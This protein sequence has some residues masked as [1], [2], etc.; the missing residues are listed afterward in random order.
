MFTFRL[1]FIELKRIGYSLPKIFIGLAVSVIFVSI[2][3][4]CAVFFV[5]AH[6]NS[7]S[8]ITVYVPEN[9][10]FF[11]M[12]VDIFSKTDGIKDLYEVNKVSDRD[13]VRKSVENGEALTGI[14]LDDNFIDSIMN[15]KENI[16]I[17]VFL[18][19]K[20]KTLNTV[21][22]N[23]ADCAKNILEY[24]QSAIYSSEMIYSEKMGM[25]MPGELNKKIN[26]KYINI[27]ASRN[28]YF[29]LRNGE[30][31][32]NLTEY[33]ISMLFP[34]FLILF[35]I[36]LGSLLYSFNKCFYKCADCGFLSVV[37][38]HNI[39]IF[40]MLFF[41]C[42]IVVAFLSAFGV[43]V[44]I[45]FFPLSFAVFSVSVIINTVYFIAD[46][47]IG[48]G[49][50]LF[51]IMLIFSFFGGA[52]VPSAFLPDWIKD[53]QIYSPVY[54]IGSQFFSLFA[55]NYNIQ[56]LF[57]NICICFF[58]YVVAFAWGCKK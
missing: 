53:I 3:A 58:C 26:I 24:V 56:N 27:F 9:N 49:V 32:I 2:A 40:I 55:E 46:G 31:D 41:V 44:N 28:N 42:F 15:G 14:V 17:N 12:A 21:I 34:I 57:Y 19:E 47:N 8:L 33:Y 29:D 43:N 23:F 13:S 51:F 36:P 35:S 18:S 10:A 39:I 1:F 25:K 38:V 22:I 54:V 50:F 30:Y 48:G 5:N 37:F 11:N 45:A 6:N 52:I 20:N 4:L 7:K 16:P